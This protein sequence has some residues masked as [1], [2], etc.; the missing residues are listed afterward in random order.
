MSRLSLLFICL[1][2]F[3]ESI[4]SKQKFYTEIWKHQAND[5]ENI[6]NF[7]GIE[8]D[9][10]FISSLNKI[11]ISHQDAFNSMTAK[12]LEE[13]IIPKNKNVWL[14]FKNFGKLNNEEINT[15]MNQL[16]KFDNQF[17]LE[18][19]NLFKLYKINKKYKNIRTIFNL[20]IFFE[21]KFY[22]QMLSK[23]FNFSSF[24]FISISKHQFN[25]VEDY[26]QSEKIFVY[27]INNKKNFCNFVKKNK[28]K[29]IL[30]RYNFNQ[31]NCK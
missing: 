25:L 6:S 29:V 13:K 7:K 2:I 27:T 31:N 1:L 9:C 12:Q 11:I 16:S 20:P 21:S 14:D 24:D 23:V 4:F 8:I 28:V 18:S 5:L 3:P 17:F 26:F 30:S 19:Q 15:A 10:Y 22:I